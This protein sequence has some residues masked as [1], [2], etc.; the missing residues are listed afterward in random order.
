MAVGLEPMG[1]LR[2]Q[3]EFLPIRAL[4]FGRV[5]GRNFRRQLPDNKFLK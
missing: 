5:V 1:I 3:S 2:E 4:G